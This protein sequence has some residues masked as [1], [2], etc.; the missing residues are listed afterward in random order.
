MSPPVDR[1]KM[2]PLLLKTEKLTIKNLNK[3]HVNRCLGTL[4]KEIKK[5][6]FQ[7]EYNTF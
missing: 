4:V 2:R 5:R 3:G 7:I 1:T 6:K